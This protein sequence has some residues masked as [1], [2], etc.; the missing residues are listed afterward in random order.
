MTKKLLLGS[1]ALIAVSLVSST[2]SAQIEMRLGGFMN[3][4]FGYGDNDSQYNLQDVDQ[5]SDTEVFFLG[6]GIHGKRPDL[7]R[8]CPA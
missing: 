1:T 8:Q 6:Q 5:W 4:W 2:A 7:R 3:Q